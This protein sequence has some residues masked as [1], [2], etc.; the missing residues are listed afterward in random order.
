MHLN[1]KKV[2]RFIYHGLFVVFLFSIFNSVITNYQEK[3]IYQEDIMMQYDRMFEYDVKALS[4]YKID[5]LGGQYFAKL[6]YG[7]LSVAQI[8]DLIQAI[9]NDGFKDDSSRKDSRKFSKGNIALCIIQYED[10][11]RVEVLIIKNDYNEK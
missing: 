11:G 2:M 8:D 4:G 10:S 7:I 9:K 5:K 6:E 3:K 1:E